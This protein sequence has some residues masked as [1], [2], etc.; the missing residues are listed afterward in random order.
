MVYYNP[1][2]DR[3]EEMGWRKVCDEPVPTAAEQKFW[4]NVMIG[5]AAFTVV[6]LFVI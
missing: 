3:S 4:G 6:M 1:K 2:L 5:Y